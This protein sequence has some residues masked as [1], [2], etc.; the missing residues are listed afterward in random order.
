MVTSVPHTAG[1]LLPQETDRDTLTSTLAQFHTSGTCS[2]TE[3]SRNSRSFPG[4]ARAR[5]FTV[6]RFYTRAK[7]NREVSRAP[8]SADT[9]TP[10]IWLH[11]PAFLAH[12][13][14]LINIRNARLSHCREALSL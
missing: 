8:R 2:N 5:V 4:D 1:L 10:G 7:A 3:A 12:S 13:V 11:L 14:L 9:T 6:D